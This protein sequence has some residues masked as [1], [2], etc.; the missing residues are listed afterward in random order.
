MQF[1]GTARSTEVGIMTRPLM[2]AKL[3]RLYSGLTIGLCPV[4]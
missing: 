2:L 1:T 4:N 3:S